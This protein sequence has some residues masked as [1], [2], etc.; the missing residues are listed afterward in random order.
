MNCSCCCT[1]VLDFCSQDIC[2]GEINF[3]I[4]AQVEGVH[5]LVV[6]YLAGQITVLA[7]LDVD[8]NIIFPIDFLSENYQYTGEIFDPTG[9]KV[10]IRKNDVDYDCIKFKTV[11]NVTV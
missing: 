11:I 3:D 5:K 2:E 9:T 8:D 6:D 7:D 1:N 10:I 4:K